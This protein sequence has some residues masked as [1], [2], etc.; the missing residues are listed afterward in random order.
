ML[1][2]QFSLNLTAHMTQQPV[3]DSFVRAT[4]AYR[5]QSKQ[6]SN[7]RNHSSVTPKLR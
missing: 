3:I 5:R 6:Q 1:N 2:R 7:E 4:L